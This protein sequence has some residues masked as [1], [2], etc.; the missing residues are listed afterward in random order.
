VYLHQ[1]E[2][3]CEA[4]ANKRHERDIHDV[5]IKEMHTHMIEIELKEEEEVK[6]HEEALK[7][8]KE[9]LRNT[10]GTIEEAQKEMCYVILLHAVGSTLCVII[11]ISMCYNFNLFYI[12]YFIFFMYFSQIYC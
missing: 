4:R 12:S 9:E 2:S 7:K 8:W 3:F 1:I 5:H 11:P 6:Q 10:G